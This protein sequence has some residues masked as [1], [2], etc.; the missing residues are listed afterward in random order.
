MTT[1]AVHNTKT[2]NETL[3]VAKALAEQQPDCPAYYL[4][5][6][7]GAGK[8]LFTKGLA[9]AYGIDTTLVVSPT[10]ALV[11]RYSG[12][13]RGLYHLDLYRI[14]KE[15]E[16]D[17]LGIEEMEEEGALVVVEWAEKLGRWRR[18]D[19]TVVHFDVLSESERRLR[20]EAQPPSSGSVSDETTVS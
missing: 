7:L 10:F 19:A 16:L 5:G 1:E 12:G 18:A 17:E 11:N 3:A 6:E 13:S 8:T 2:P 4:E 20:V 9:A 14:E 15:R